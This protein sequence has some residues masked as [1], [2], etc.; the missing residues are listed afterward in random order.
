MAERHLLPALG[1]E[2]NEGKTRR[3]KMVTHFRKLGLLSFA[4]ESIGKF[5]E[6]GIMTNDEQEIHFFRLIG[7]NCLKRFEA[8]AIKCR[9]DLGFEFLRGT[10]FEPFESLACAPCRRYEGEIRDKIRTAKIAAHALRHFEAGRTQR[11]VKVA[12]FGERQSLSVTEKGK[13]QHGTDAA[14]E[15]AS[16]IIA[17]TLGV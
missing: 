1:I 11:P 8:G 16:R 12:A 15:R 2:I 17:P 6:T 14:R 10:L 7:K 9:N 13:V 3:R 4:D 5:R